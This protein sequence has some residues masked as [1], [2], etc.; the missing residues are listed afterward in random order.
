VSTTTTDSLCAESPAQSE[1]GVAGSSRIIS[2]S[3]T[4]RGERI[5]FFAHCGVRIRPARHT[6]QPRRDAVRT[7][8]PV[9]PAE[10]PAAAAYSPHL[11]SNANSLHGAI[12]VKSPN[13]MAP[14]RWILFLTDSGVRVRYAQPRSQ[15]SLSWDGRRWRTSGGRA[16]LGSR[17]GF[18]DCYIDAN[19]VNDAPTVSFR[20]MT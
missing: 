19:V 8:A 15:V 2:R 12:S 6:E 7:S 9:T 10:I 20:W 18:E 11:S 16:R 4:D 14:I 5:T 3:A 13:V 1:H 17:L